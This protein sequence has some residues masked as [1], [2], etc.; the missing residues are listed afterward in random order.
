MRPEKRAAGLE[1]AKV[2]GFARW[3]A[4]AV[5]GEKDEIFEGIFLLFPFD[6]RQLKRDQ[7]A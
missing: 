3:A 6:A 2:T 5:R 4:A 1:S 7:V